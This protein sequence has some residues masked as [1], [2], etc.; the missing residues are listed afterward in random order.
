MPK[1][2]GD[3]VRKLLSAGAALARERGCGA[4]SVRE[5]CR[6]ANVNLGLFHYHFKSREAF[7]QR[8]LEEVYRDFF[9]R[10]SVS[11]ES[12]GSPPERLRRALRSIAHFARERRRMLAGLLR[13]GMNGERKVADFVSQNFPRH[14]PLMFS[15]YEE[16]VRRGDFRRLPTP[17]FM[18]FCMAAINGPGIL[19][20]LLEEHGARRPFGRSVAALQRELLSDEA[21]ETRLDMLLAALSAPQGRP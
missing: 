14:L 2:A 13:D 21:I 7:V 20:T 9:S 12:G 4:I 15:L 19:L 3:A 6:R 8:V 16:G 10:L 17:F 5:T 11:A 18:S 1:P